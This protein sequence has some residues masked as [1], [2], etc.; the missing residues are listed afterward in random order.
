MSSFEHECLLRIFAA[1][2]CISMPLAV[3]HQ[4]LNLHA[5][6][7][8]RTID[9]RDQ[10]VLMVDQTATTTAAAAADGPTDPPPRPWLLAVKLH[11]P[12]EALQFLD[13]AQ[14]V[15]VVVAMRDL[16]LSDARSNFRLQEA[17]AT[18]VRAS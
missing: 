15:G 10:W 12:R 2:H 6:S 5:D 11:A 17:D 16:R 14:H 18:D 1:F 7:R 8:M 3:S 9:I 13:P 4:L